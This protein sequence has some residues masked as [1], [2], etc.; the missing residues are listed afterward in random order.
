MR[1]KE[2][3]EIVCDVQCLLPAERLV[4]TVSFSRPATSWA[5]GRT[6]RCLFVDDVMLLMRILLLLLAAPESIDCYNSTKRVDLN[7][8]LE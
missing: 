3:Q 4:V 6:S 8:S 7:I 2:K 5:S 1:V